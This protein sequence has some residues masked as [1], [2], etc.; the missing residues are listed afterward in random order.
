VFIL[1]FEPLCFVLSWLM[2]RFS[3]CSSYM[4]VKKCASW[5]LSFEYESV[6]FSFLL[7]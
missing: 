7:I 3:D 4:A 1:L 2:S 6:S 5:G